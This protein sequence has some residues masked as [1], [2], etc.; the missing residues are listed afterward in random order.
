MEYADDGD[1]YQKILKYQKANQ[2][3]DEKDIWRVMIEMT[4][5]LNILHQIKIFHRDLKSANVFLN[6]NNNSKL[7]DLNVSKVAKKGLL[8]TQTG[9]PYYASPEVWRDQPYDSKSDIWSLGCVIYEMTT[10]KPPFRAQDMNGLYK[11]VLRGAYPEVPKKYTK[12]LADIIRK[13]LNVDP[14]QRPSCQ[15]ILDSEQV[16]KRAARLFGDV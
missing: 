11:K 13:F 5:A 6:K 12:D 16:S 10:L 15:Q 3:M 9:T 4:R 14:K 8:Y 1:L 2:L 7:G